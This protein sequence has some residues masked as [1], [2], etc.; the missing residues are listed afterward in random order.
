MFLF[1]AGRKFS[2][3]SSNSDTRF[4]QG[5]FEGGPLASKG[6]VM[7]NAK[8]LVENIIESADSA[9]KNRS[10]AATLRFGHDGNVI[11]LLALLADRK[12]RCG[13]GRSC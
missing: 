7:A 9:M 6:I 4:Q 12:L 1:V 2:S 3:F 8:T 5:L 13:C 10:I 11:P